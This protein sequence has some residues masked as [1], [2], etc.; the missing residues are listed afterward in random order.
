[1]PGL[2]ASF[3]PLDCT[4]LLQALNCYIY[5]ENLKKRV[6]AGSPNALRARR[7]ELE[8]EVKKSEK[9]T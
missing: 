9:R 6:K 7:K 4:P 1:M 8:R 2:I 5:R 3:T